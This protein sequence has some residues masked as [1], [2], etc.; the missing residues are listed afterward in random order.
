MVSGLLQRKICNPFY[1]TIWTLIAVL[2]L[3]LNLLVRTLWLAAFPSTATA[4]VDAEGYFLLAR[5]MLA[6]NGFAI[7]WEQPFCPTTIR[8]PVYPFFVLISLI[9]T[10]QVP[11]RVVL[12]HLLCEVAT[13]GIAMRMAA[14]IAVTA[15]ANYHQGRIAGILAG[16]LYA[17]NGTTQRYTGFLYAENLLLPILAIAVLV[18][19]RCLRYGSLRYGLTAGLFWALAILTKPNVQYMAFGAG[20]VLTLVMV[21]HP[22]S[23]QRK[24]LK[25]SS[26]WL[27]MGILLFPWFYRN[28]KIANQWMVSS[29]FSE[30]ASRVAAVAL[31]AELKSVRAEPWTTTWEYLYDELVIITSVKE[32]WLFTQEPRFSC[33]R[34]ARQ[35]SDI[36]KAAQHLIFKHFPLYIKVHMQGVIQSLLNPGHELWYRILTG[37]PWSSSGT[38]SD[39]W[40][41]LYWSLKRAA[42]EEAIKTFIRQR[43]TTIQPLAGFVWW[44]LWIGKIAVFILMLKGLS[45]LYKHRWCLFLLVGIIMY[46]IIL[47]GPISHDRF[48]IPAIPVVTALVATGLLKRSIL[49][50]LPRGT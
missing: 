13:C 48:Y 34:I 29:A 10:G 50:I 26:F 36:A 16:F 43:M 23:R 21:K 25:A 27:A 9:L 12:M 28:H 46:I 37:K 19:L 15:G 40:E 24:W 30:N 6:G 42:V 33:Q 47:P 20:M 14:D 4:P 39:I 22:S 8:T 31:M 38:V 45:L 49:P 5:N 1:L 41:R 11:Q 18:T 17:I 35:H 3:L 44:V 7:A 32:G 2:V